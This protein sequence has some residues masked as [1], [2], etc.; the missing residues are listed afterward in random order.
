MSTATPPVTEAAEPVIR[1]I[2]PPK[3]WMPLN[4]GELWQY[5]EMTLFLI[6]RELKIRYKQTVLGIFWA[7]LQPFITMIVFSFVFGRI[8]R[9][10]SDGI[11][12]PLFS[13]VGLLPWNFFSSGLSKASTSLNSNSSLIK[14]IYFPRLILPVTAILS[15]L[16]DFFLGTVMLAIL[17]IY[18]AAAVAPVSPLVVNHAIPFI[19]SDLALNAFNHAVRNYEITANVVWLPLL[20]LLSFTV[21]LS[22]S[23]WFAALNVRFRD[24]AVAIGFLV[25]ILLYLTPVIYP[26]SRLDGVFQ[27]LAALNPMTGVIEGF[28][29]ALLGVDTAPGIYV[30]ISAA[31]SILLLIG[32]LYYFRRTESTFADLI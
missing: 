25:R 31:M 15:G 2:E 1:V 30:L 29:W 19:N 20:L 7:I 12:Y 13:Y 6:F 10:P 3:R 11:P 27:V 24:V 23:L 21:A 16:V 5:R 4:L 28:R 18:F 22:L 8:A 26:I 9:M 14:K 32:G 17:Y